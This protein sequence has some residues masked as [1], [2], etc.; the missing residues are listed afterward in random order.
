MTFLLYFVVIFQNLFIYQLSQ[1]LFRKS[2]STSFDC[3]NQKPFGD[4]RLD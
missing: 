4:S 2:C 1:Y 3:F